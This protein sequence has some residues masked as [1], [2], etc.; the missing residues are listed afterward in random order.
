MKRVHMFFKGHSKLL[1]TL[2]KTS[3][4]INGQTGKEDISMEPQNKVL[5]CESPD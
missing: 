5:A 3:R 4:C 1:A 2:Y